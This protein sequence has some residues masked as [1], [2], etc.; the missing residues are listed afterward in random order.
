MVQFDLAEFCCKKSAPII[1]LLLLSV[2]AY[3][4]VFPV[5][6]L[7]RNG[8]RS[9][10]INIAYLADG[11]QAAELN[12]FFTNASAI[13]NQLFSQSPFMEYK[14]FFNSFSVRVPSIQSGAAHP[15]TASDCPPLTTQPITAPVT[16]FQSSFDQFFIHRLLVPLNPGA[17]NSVLASNLP[18]YDQAFVVVNSPFY[19][20][21]GGAYATASTEANSA[22]VAIHEIGHSFA[23]LADE[24]WAG[25]FYAAE[26]PNMTAINNPDS[27]KWKN[28]LGINGIGIYPVGTTA[29]GISWYRPH[30]NCKMQALGQPFCSVCKEA[31]TDR[32]HELVN[33][34][35]NILPV[36]TSFTLGNTDPVSFSL[37]AVQNNPSTISVRWYLN[38]S[39]TPF[40]TDQFDVTLTF[41]SFNTGNNT[42][43][44]EI[45]DNTDLS[46]SYLP[47]VGY[48]N[49][50]TW[51]V[52]NPGTLPVH[53][54]VFSGKVNNYRGIL[55]WEIETPGDLKNFEL[56]KSSN[57]VAFSTLASINGVVQQSK[58]TY[59]DPDLLVPYSYYRLKV[60]EKNGTAF[61]S[62][63]IRLQNAFDKFYYKVYQ[64]SDAKRYHL[65]VRLLQPQ[66]VSM[67]LTDGTGKIIVRKDFG[68]I[69]SQLE[70]DFNLAGKSAGIYYMV[71]NMDNKV[72]TTQL[73]AN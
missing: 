16:F 35:D 9:N 41:T 59:T 1:T 5:D 61:Y 8:T 19:G 73:L 62:P 14:N 7:M 56:E 31:L 27:I 18:D 69:D 23:G 3:N 40:A 28:W 50:L 24:Y 30:Q 2:N 15:H 66:S 6:T 53:L 63:V 39:A 25:D 37:S 4:Q 11:Y 67:Q 52:I 58:Y 21:S 13:N 29:G 65:S 12:T 48:I 26:K 55:N 64:Q 45:I 42:V 36:A 70:Y 22:E 60:K 51:N 32:I 44:A 54:K 34:A 10:R 17:I 57:G 43:R 72:Y 38:G 20:G 46:K 68:R 47:G 33:M 71:L 49:N